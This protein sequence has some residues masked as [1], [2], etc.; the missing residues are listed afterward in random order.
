MFFEVQANAR[1]MK[2]TRRPPLPFD[3]CCLEMALFSERHFYMRS[4]KCIG[5]SMERI[6][7]HFSLFCH[8]K[9][10]LS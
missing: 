9:L 5:I 10:R 6:V 3:Y 2:F 8:A 7:I 1:Q 4:S